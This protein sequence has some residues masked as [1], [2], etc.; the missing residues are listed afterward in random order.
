MET[1]AVVMQH[2]FSLSVIFYTTL[3]VFLGITVGAIPGLSG[4]MAIALLLPFV[5]KLSPEVAIGMLMGIY[6]GSMFG[7]SISA[8][9]FGVPGTPAAIATVNDGYPAN[10]AGRPKQALMTALYSSV[11]GDFLSTALLVF[12]AVPMGRIALQFG[13]VEYFALYVFALMMISLLVVGEMKKG[14]A[15]AGIG[16][17]LGCIGMDPLIGSTRLTL[18]VG[19]LRGGI[20]MLSVLIGVFALPELMAQFADEYRRAR[21]EKKQREDSELKESRSDEYDTSR[22]KWSLAVYLSTFKSTMIGT[23]VGAFIGALPG[24]GSS[25][26]ALMGYGLSRKASKQPEL[27]GT[28]VL[29]GIAAPE[30]ANSATAGASLI[31]LFAFGIPG[32]A[33]A[34]LIGAALVMQ[35]ISPGPM[36]IEENSVVIYTLFLILLYA[37]FINLFLSL[38]LIPLYAKLA[39]VK[40]RYLI[41][42]VFALA[43]IG[44]YA[45]RNSLTD[46]WIAL[47]AGVMG[48]S[49]RKFEY[50][51]GPLVLGFIVGP[52]TEK[53]LRQALLMGRGNVLFLFKSPIA[54]G[55][56]F[57]CLLSLVMIHLSLKKHVIED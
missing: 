56:Y 29:E 50:P 28:G 55:F 15:A 37:T 3:G 52:G 17:F 25:L 20:P 12:L 57:V 9:T 46:V 40:P 19:S 22:D 38:G 23:A 7:G 32:S 36:M 34:A 21:Y 47:A 18:G 8:I 39:K 53:A 24:A 33:T 26:A 30:A 14:I 6:K 49:L 27:Y 2:A 5:F 4:D 11:T 42:C 41:P 48:V 54:L 45:S 35:G 16:L 10:K 13:P 1:L 43:L 44:V 51:L 31:P